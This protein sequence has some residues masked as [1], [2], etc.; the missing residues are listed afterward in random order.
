VGGRIGLKL[1]EKIYY[2]INIFSGILILP[3]VFKPPDASHLINK[4][5]Y[6]FDHFVIGV[7]LTVSFGCLSAEDG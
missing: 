4:N 3:P 5:I 7:M 6:L 1:P 2:F